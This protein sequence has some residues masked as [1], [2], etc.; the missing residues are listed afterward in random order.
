GPVTNFKI[1]LMNSTLI[2]L[3]IFSVAIASLITACKNSGSVETDKDTG[4]QY[5]FFNHDEKG[6]KAAIGDYATLKMT[7][8]A[9]TPSGA[10]TEVFNTMKNRRPGDTSGGTITI[11]LTKTFNGCLEQAVTLMAAGDSAMFKIN[12]DSLFLKTFHQKQLPKH[13]KTDTTARVNVKRLPK[14]TQQQ[15]KQKNPAA[16]AKRQAKMEQ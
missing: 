15:M 1:R 5:Q 2:R 13:M 10:D 7:Y 9:V 16:M 3:S 14:R 8:H 6:T 12:I 11:P 4:I